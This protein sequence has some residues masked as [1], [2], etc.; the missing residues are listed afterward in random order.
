MIDLEL[1]RKNPEVVKEEIKKRKRELS[2]FYHPDK[3][4]DYSEDVQKLA[5]EQ[6]KEINQALQ[7][8]KDKIK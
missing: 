6:L 3:A 8:L 7:T 4:G 2:F 5:E 1:L